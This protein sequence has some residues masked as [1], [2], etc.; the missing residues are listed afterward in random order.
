[1]PVH[2][3]SG[4]RETAE[5]RF[6]DGRS[7]PRAILVLVSSARRNSTSSAPLSSH[8]GLSPGSPASDQ[9]PPDSGSRSAKGPGRTHPPGP[10][11]VRPRLQGAGDRIV[12]SR[13]LRTAPSPCAGDVPRPRSRRARRPGIPVPLNLSPLLIG[14][15][16]VSRN[17]LGAVSA[18]K[19][20]SA[21]RASS[22]W[23]GP[24]WLI[25]GF[26]SSVGMGASNTGWSLLAR[27]TKRRSG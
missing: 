6:E 24:L 25:T 2:V 11:L 14:R 7:N 3:G 8:A 15:Y 21:F 1:V 27:M 9:F 4:G 18:R 17:Y 12:G 5:G 19:A 16:V 26:F 22:N 20:F 10:R 13:A 23:T